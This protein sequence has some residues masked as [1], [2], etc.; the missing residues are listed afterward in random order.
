MSTI[1]TVIIYTFYEFCVGSLTKKIPKNLTNSDPYGTLAKLTS[2]G[3]T[4]LHDFNTLN[5]HRFYSDYL[6]I[7]YRHTNDIKH[8]FIFKKFLLNVFA[9]IM[10]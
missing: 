10:V 6:Q 9:L 1:K 3:S 4:F 8:S 2:D 7:P 5:E